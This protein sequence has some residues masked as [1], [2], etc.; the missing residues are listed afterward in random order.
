MRIIVFGL[1]AVGGVVAARLHQG[2]TDVVGVARGAHLAAVKANGLAVRSIEGVDNV[3]LPVVGGLSELTP[4]QDDVVLI[5]TKTQDAPAVHDALAAWNPGV[6]VVCG[7]NGVEQ[8][9]MVL[10]RFARTYAMVVN[11]PAVLHTP[12]E[13]TALCHPLNALLDVG[14]FPS[15]ID[16]V[17]EEFAAVIAASPH[18]D[19]IA[20]PNVMAKKYAKLIVNLGNAGEAAIGQGGRDAAI[21]KVATAEART[22]YAAAGIELVDDADYRTRLGGLSFA[23]PPGARFT[24]GSTWQSLARGADSVEIDYLNGEVV[25]LGRLH[26]VATPANEVLQRLINRL[27]RQGSAGASL[28][29]ADLDALIPASS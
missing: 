20:D 28:T 13:V 5:T 17:A 23:I 3:R 11:L 18:L 26:G 25:L 7:S 14:C 6:A 8:E 29:V 9:R 21:V 22:V 24:G 19:S 2:G 10:R 27:S 16:A 1:G 15:G 4:Q 12:G